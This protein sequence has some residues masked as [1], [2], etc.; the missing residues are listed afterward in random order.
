MN[1]NRLIRAGG[2]ALGVI[3]YTGLHPVSPWYALLII[4]GAVIY[5]FV[6]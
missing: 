1:W 5:I 4:A 6:P 2:I 3:G